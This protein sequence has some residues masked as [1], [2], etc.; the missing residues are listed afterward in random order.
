MEVKVSV[1]QKEHGGLEP[2][3]VRDGEAIGQEV[4][5]ADVA[6]VGYSMAFVAEARVRGP[7]PDCRIVHVWDRK[8]RQGRGTEKWP[9][10]QFRNCPLFLELSAEQKAPRIQSA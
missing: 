7:C 8:K 4:Q 10:D 6:Q 2:S 1:W 9:S 5:D 3:V